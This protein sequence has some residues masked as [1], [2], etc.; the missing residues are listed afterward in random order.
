MT[1]ASPAAHNRN[2]QYLRG[3]AVLLVLG[4]HLQL[5]GMQWGYLGVDLFFLVSGFLMP[6]ILPRYDAGTY[7]LARVKRIYPALLAAIAVCFVLGWI[8]MMPGE[9]DGFS[10]SALAAIGSVSE[11]WFAGN[12]GY[13]D[14]PQQT[15]PLLHTWS[16]GVEFLCY[17]VVALM[18]FAARDAHQRGW[19]ALG[20]TLLL[21]AAFAAMWWV[22]GEDI[23]YF[24]PLPRMAL[25]FL[26]FWI[27]SRRRSMGAVP[28]I[29]VTL[30]GGALL[31]MLFGEGLSAQQFP[32][33]AALLLPLVGLPVLM[34]ARPLPLPRLLAGPLGWLGDISYSLYIWHW[35]VI[36]FQML[37]FRNFDVR[38]WEAPILAGIS[39]LVATGSYYLIER[40]RLLRRGPVIGTGA[41]ILALLAAAGVRTDGF[42][43]RLP[44][45]LVPYTAIDDMRDPAMAECRGDIAGL[46]VHMPCREGRPFADT[47]LFVGDSHAR[48]FMPLFDAAEP[49]T[50][51]MR[52]RATAGE[53]AA[54]WPAIRRLAD[55]VNA[56]R[57]YVAYRWYGEDEGEVAALVAAMQTD[58]LPGAVLVRDVPAWNFN[59]VGC[60]VQQNA[61][62]FHGRCDHDLRQ[63]VPASALENATGGSWSLAAAS[64]LPT[65]DTQ[66][67][68]CP[69]GL[70][71]VL[72]DGWLIYRDTNHLHALLPPEVE[73]WLYQQLFAADRQAVPQQ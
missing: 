22:Q 72:R 30:A 45:A 38:L 31:A 35:P 48:H 71:P 37:A 4:F 65:I 15:H 47:V 49:A 56:S 29:A 20:L 42:A 26:A 28:A 24:N 73:R 60:W 14:E 64:G 32:G 58:P 21:A 55:R 8:T 19:L 36:V 25:F 13:F 1:S 18:L 27:S 50:R 70:C 51:I 39:L 41:V 10:Q 54:E 57:V 44:A 9:M 61:S 52:H 63:P 34:L 66:A 2:I 33:P 46:N 59:P 5:P 67:L 43:F 3:V 40:N 16:L 53:A 7:L 11:F 23:S 62:L 69:Q 17:A 68:L 6:L 12:T